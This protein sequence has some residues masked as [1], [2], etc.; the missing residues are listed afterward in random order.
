M[1]NKLIAFV[2][3]LLTPWQFTFASDNRAEP[4][5]LVLSNWASQRINSFILGG[6]YE[7][8]GYSV[9]YLELDVDSQWGALSQDEVQV[10]VEVWEGTMAEA[11][12]NAVAAGGIAD[13]G[14]YIASSREEW[15]YPS[16]IEEQCPKL[17]DWRALKDCIAFVNPRVPGSQGVYVTGP[18]ETTDELRIAA[19]GLPFSVEKLKD[20]KELWKRLEAAYQNKEPILM[21]N[22][23][24]NFIDEVYE[25]RFVEFPDHSPD[26]ETNPTWGINPSATHDCGNQKT[27]WI[28]KISSSKF[29][30]DKPEAFKLLQNFN[31]NSQQFS[32]IIYIKEVLGISDKKAAKLWLNKNEKIWKAWL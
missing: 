7:Q 13:A 30:Q 17:P 8:Q 28:K 4:I 29:K 6:L 3:I 23:T 5:K 16:Y 24:P 26:C 22:W 14:S 19:L 10:Q 1:I 32:Q 25:G 31:L 27:G 12:D 18:W 15:W 2:I 20:D 9:K 21:L 11:F